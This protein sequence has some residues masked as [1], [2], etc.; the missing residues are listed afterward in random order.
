[1]ENEIYKSLLIVGVTMIFVTFFIPFVKKIA[2]HIGAIDDKYANL[3]VISKKIQGMEYKPLIQ[4][5]KDYLIGLACVAIL[6]LLLHLAV[7]KLQAVRKAR[8]ALAQ[9]QNMLNKNG[10]GDYPT[11]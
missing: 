10:G 5:I 7:S 1:M 4:R 9:Y 2:K 3:Q 11:I 6:V 8:K